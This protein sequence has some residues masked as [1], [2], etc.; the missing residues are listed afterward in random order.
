M[1]VNALGLSGRALC[2]EVGGER[3]SIMKCRQL[4]PQKFLNRGRYIAMLYSTTKRQLQYA[5]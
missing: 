1:E 3:L 5:G 4:R 2:G